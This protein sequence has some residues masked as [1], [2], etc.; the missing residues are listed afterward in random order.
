MLVWIC[1]GTN[2]GE[3]NPKFPCPTGA[4]T[5]KRAETP[6]SKV[7]PHSDLSRE[8][9]SEPDSGPED[10]SDGFRWRVVSSPPES[11]QAEIEVSTVNPNRC[12]GRFL[13][14]IHRTVP[15][16]KDL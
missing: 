1:P 10:R 16:Q 13:Q 8:N 7:R 6:R 4:E 11:R 12:A 5:V 9:Y 2:P 14:S 3:H 15:G